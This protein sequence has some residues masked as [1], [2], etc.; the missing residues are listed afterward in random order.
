[1]RIVL[2]SSEAVPFAKTGGLADVASALAKALA[3]LGHEVRLVLPYYVARCEW[4]ARPK[5]PVRPV[6]DAIDVRIGERS[7]SGR[8]LTT[9]L[10]GT[11]VPVWLVDQPAYFARVPLYQERGADFADNCERF[12]FFSRAVLEAARRFEG[13]DV[14]HLNDWQTG[15]VPALLEIEGRDD[16]ALR[17]AA[18]VFT[19]HN[20]A[21][22]GVFWHHDMP[23]TGLGWEHFTWRE[24]ESYGRLNLMKTGLVFANRLT[25]VSPTYAKEI[26]TKEF[27]CGL[28]GVLEERSARLAGI[29]NGVDTDEWD[30]ATD[31]ALPKTYDARS[32]EQG[33]SI[34]KQ[35]L[36]T[37]LGLPVRSDVP[38]FGMISRMADQKGFDLIAQ[39]AAD[40]LAHDVQLCFLGT[41]ERRYEDL[42]RSLA[43]RHPDRIAA[44]IGFDEG[45]AHRIEAGCDAYLMPSRYEPCGLNQLYSL[46]Y[47]TVP[48]VRAVGGLADSVVDV[49]E[50]HLAAGTANGFSFREATGAALAHAVGR[51]AAAYR[52]RGTWRQLVATGMAQDWSWTRSARRYVEIYESALGD[53]RGRPG[54]N[55]TATSSEV[56][57]MSLSVSSEAREAAAAS[58]PPESSPRRTARVS[59]SP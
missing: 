17:S 18:S 4:D 1:M 7:V 52:D 36:Q 12:V 32:W 58:V 22:Q 53:V 37:E 29:L 9:T 50:A 45:L 51:A 47:G 11:D 54:A 35:A 59:R 2:A 42:L 30:P 21:Y 43:E 15:L 49:D 14:L 44:T 48:V 46:I 55:G 19:I 13:V 31:R 3:E 10:P 38:L 20:L 34:C 24:M 6:P 28:E 16:P 26:R 5:Y 56:S 41:G 8:F 25:T 39:A 23:L 33:K 57:S 40:I 27:G